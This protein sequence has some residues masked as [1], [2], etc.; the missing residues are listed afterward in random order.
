MVLAHAALKLNATRRR[1]TVWRSLE[2]PKAGFRRRS[3]THS[4]VYDAMCLLVRAGVSLC[5]CV[6]AQRTDLLTHKSCLPCEHGTSMHFVHQRFPS[7]A[8]YAFLGRSTRFARRRY[9]GF[10]RCTPC[11]TWPLQRNHLVVL[12]RER[13][14]VVAALAAATSAGDAGNFEVAAE[15]VAE[16][17]DMLRGDNS[18]DA[19]AQLVV[20]LTT[21]ASHIE[22]LR[23][24]TA[25]LSPGAMSPLRG[26]RSAHAQQRASPAV[27]LYMTTEQQRLVAQSPSA[28][29]TFSLSTPPVPRRPTKPLQFRATLQQ[30]NRKN[31]TAFILQTYFVLASLIIICTFIMYSVYK[32]YKPGK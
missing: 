12:Q 7:L 14:V 2:F 25:P 8:S 32:S 18:S 20:A 28:K 4:T 9:A 1:P 17:L 10:V 13:E 23:A 16:A 19:R 27:P 3:R 26:F 24:I 21:A 11:L 29:N 30:A 5:R 6:S 15:K 22:R 31:S